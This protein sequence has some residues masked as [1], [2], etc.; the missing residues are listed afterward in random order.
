MCSFVKW[1]Y[2]ITHK[3]G[4]TND[5]I[6]QVVNVVPNTYSPVY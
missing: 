4:D 5:P 2:C 1:V 6:T 3:V